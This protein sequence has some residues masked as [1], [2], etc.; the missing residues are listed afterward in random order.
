MRRLAQRFVVVSLVIPALTAVTPTP[1]AAETRRDC[2]DLDQGVGIHGL[3]SIDTGC[4]SSARVARL[5]QRRC[6]TLDRR[7]GLGNGYR[8]R[9]RR[10]RYYTYHVRCRRQNQ[11]V[12]FRF[13]AD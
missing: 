3:R 5:W 10:G 12:W 1:A 11:R 13:V 7:C 4:R 2:G 9:T 6:S 8:C